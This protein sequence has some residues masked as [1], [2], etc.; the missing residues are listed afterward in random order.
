MKSDTVIEVI[1]TSQF[2]ALL[3]LSEEC[4]TELFKYAT[5]ETIIDDPALITAISGGMGCNALAYV[6][7]S[8]LCVKLENITHLTNLKYLA[9]VFLTNGANPNLRVK[10][11]PNAA[12]FFLQFLFKYI[13]HQADAEVVLQG[14][15]SADLLD[16][17]KSFAIL[18]LEKGAEF[19]LNAI[20][21]NLAPTFV[22][23]RSIEILEI[24][25]N[26]IQKPMQTPAPLSNSIIPI[27]INNN[28][29]F[30][31][32]ADIIDVDMDETMGY[33]V[34]SSSLTQ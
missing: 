20:E 30:P 34:P 33:D 17:Y 28:N 21:K 32:S 2:E 9:E 25:F 12:Y 18:L 16:P 8:M 29:N 15:I 7:A 24:F 13:A 27:D 6:I 19:D 26:T 5:Q 4:D 3:E 14:K 22:L 23:R 31:Q 1:F 10:N 11:K